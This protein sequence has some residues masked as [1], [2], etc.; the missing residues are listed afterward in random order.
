MTASDSRVALVILKRSVSMSKSQWRS[1]STRRTLDPI[2]I[3]DFVSSA[4]AEWQSNPISPAIVESQI[5]SDDQLDCLPV[6][7]AEQTESSGVFLLQFV[8]GGVRLRI[9]EE[10]CRKECCRPRQLSQYLTT[11]EPWKP[12]RVLLNGKGHTWD[13]PYYVL[14]DYHLVLC[15]NTERKKHAPQLFDLQ[16]NLR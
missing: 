7:K 2:A 8:A 12:V 1:S 5:K 9:S 14:Q 15:D 10:G 13:D 3:E 16:I 11:L 4:F 6:R